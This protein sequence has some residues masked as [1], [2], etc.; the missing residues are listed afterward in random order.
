DADVHVAEAERAG[1]V[2]VGAGGAV[3]F[4]AGVLREAALVD[5]RHSAV[6]RLHEALARVVEDPV[7][8]IRHG[9]LSH[10]RCD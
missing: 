5:V 2:T 6:I 1:V 7:Q 10:D 4:T 8:A 3:A 9:L